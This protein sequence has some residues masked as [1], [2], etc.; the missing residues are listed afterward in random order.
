MRHQWLSPI[1]PERKGFTR[2]QWCMQ[3]QNRHVG[4]ADGLI[5]GLSALR[6]ENGEPLGPKGAETGDAHVVFERLGG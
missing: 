4:V 3:Q 6:R 1:P 2:S 5:L